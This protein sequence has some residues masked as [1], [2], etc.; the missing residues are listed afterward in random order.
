MNQRRPMRMSGLTIVLAACAA[1]LVPAGCVSET[2][3]LPRHQGQPGMKTNARSGADQPKRESWVVRPYEA[4][5]TPV[6]VHDPCSNRLHDLV[7]SFLLY[8][9]KHRRFPDRLEELKSVGADVSTD[10]LS[11]PACDKPYVYRPDGVML[12]GK[13]HLFVLYDPEEAVV[14]HKGLRFGLALQ[15]PGKGEAMVFKVLP[16]SGPEWV[17]VPPVGN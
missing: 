7:G 4:G 1:A 9:A 3:T 5:T 11:C 13:N 17:E 2:K 10:A 14:A 16:I 15:E 6:S 8:H 12:H